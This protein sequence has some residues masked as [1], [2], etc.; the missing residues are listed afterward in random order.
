VNLLL[1]MNLSPDL[2]A[3][4]S[5]HGHD[6]LH[7]STVGDMRAT[8]LTI[9]NWSREHDR[10]VVTH[11]LDFGT[12]L[13]NTDATGPSVIQIREQDLLAAATAESIAKAIT[14][15]APALARGAVV[16]VHEDRSRIRILPLRA[17]TSDED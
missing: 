6:V 8:D 16:T 11:D 1:D 3:M 12:I 15:A 14:A 4:L 10:V 17:R 13:W 9:L 7:W 2:V 5:R